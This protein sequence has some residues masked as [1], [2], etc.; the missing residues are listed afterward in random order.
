MLESLFVSIKTHVALLR[1]RGGG[2]GVPFF[3]GVIRNDLESI[4]VGFF[5]NATQITHLHQSIGSGGCVQFR[6]N[7]VDARI[8]CFLIPKWPP[9]PRPYFARVFHCE[10]TGQGHLFAFKHNRYTTYLGPGWLTK[11]PWTAQNRSYIAAV[12]LI[13]T[14][15]SIL[16]LLATSG[17]I[18]IDF[19]G[20]LVHHFGL[21]WN[22]SRVDCHEILSYW[23][24]RSPDFSSVATSRSTYPVTYLYIFSADT[25]GDQDQGLFIE[26]HNPDKV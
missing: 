19:S 4:P 11:G 13:T 22:I 1:Q 9:F 25:Y 20:R 5:K 6:V 15:V 21:Y 7:A 14:V 23:L 12:P 3:L 18:W 24:W 10:V 16:W 8:C 17:S 2:G 26:R